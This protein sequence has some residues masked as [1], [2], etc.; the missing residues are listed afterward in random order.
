MKG[1][2]FS[3][4]EYLYGFYKAFQPINPCEKYGGSIK[5]SYFLY[6]P[7]NEGGAK[8]SDEV[9]ISLARAVS[10]KDS[11]E[12]IKIAEKINDLFEKGKR[13]SFSCKL[14]DKPSLWFKWKR[15]GNVKGEVEG[16]FHQI[17]EKGRGGITILA[18]I[19][20]GEVGDDLFI[21]ALPTLEPLMGER[22]CE[23]F[24]KLWFFSGSPS[25]RN[26]VKYLIS[27]TRPLRFVW[28]GELSD[29]QN[30]YGLY[31]MNF[32]KRLSKEEILK[33][34][35]DRIEEMQELPEERIEKLWRE[36]EKIAHQLFKELD[37]FHNE[38][39]ERAFRLAKEKVQGLT[40]ITYSYS[41]AGEKYSA[42]FKKYIPENFFIIADKPGKVE[43]DLADNLK[44]AGSFKPKKIPRVLSAEKVSLYNFSWLGNLLLRKE[45]TRK[46]APRPAFYY[47]AVAFALYVAIVVS[48]SRSLPLFG[49]SGK[50]KEEDKSDREKIIDQFIAFS[51]LVYGLGTM[52]PFQGY[53]KETMKKGGWSYKIPNLLHSSAKDCKEV[54][55]SL[56]RGGN[57][58]EFGGHIIKEITTGFIVPSCTLE[59]EPELSPLSL[60]HRLIEFYRYEVR[61][62]GEKT[63]A[64]IKLLGRLIRFAGG[65][66]VEVGNIPRQLENP[67][68]LVSDHIVPLHLLS[69]MVVKRYGQIKGFPIK[70]RVLDD[71][72]LTHFR[73]NQGKSDKRAYL[74]LKE[75]SPTYSK[76]IGEILKEAK[77]R[78]FYTIFAPLPPTAKRIT[79]RKGFVTGHGETYLVYPDTKF[80]TE[81]AG[82]LEVIFLALGIFRNDLNTDFA[83]EKNYLSND[84]KAVSVKRGT[85]SYD[86]PFN[87]LLVEGIG[88]LAS[89][90]KV[91]VE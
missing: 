17:K 51:R 8:V 90:F 11:K 24:R 16:E 80:W 28:L 79:G 59:E 60:R 25:F 18:V 56:S 58:A 48:K 7:V 62:D 53:G 21:R 2:F 27:H 43:K 65:E 13:E 88:R 29:G 87:S 66:E 12:I 55:L 52:L 68:F 4:S 67:I 34:A 30:L 35:K 46:G 57:P 15:E 32:M 50:E 22:F 86:F 54:K 61:R 70:V 36:V 71:Y 10:K 78:H 74:L 3:G 72:P 44:T 69:E 1:R 73:S 63:E 82:V 26:V 37:K 31:P 75:N 23:L 33:R 89:I 64:R 47:L 45:F 81:N 40:V 9:I 91:K 39:K 38:F 42:L 77:D 85:Y 5:G 14:T 20:K 83:K 19:P 6:P 41:K 76:A 49:F 84:R